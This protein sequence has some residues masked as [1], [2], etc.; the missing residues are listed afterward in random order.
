M[1]APSR[2]ASNGGPPAEPPAH[3]YIPNSAP[4]VRRQMLDAIGI[5]SVDE[6]YASV[7][8]ELRL[9]RPLDLPAPLTDEVALRRHVQGL[10]N[11]NT[12]T[13]EVVSFLGGGC[14]DLHVP[15]VVDE[16]TGRAEFVTAYGGG[17]YADHGKYQILFEFQSLIGELVGMDVVSAPTYDGITATTSALLMACRLTNRGR[18]LVPATVNPQL[19]EHLRTF[20]RPWATVE[21]IPA[22]PAS[23]L[24]DLEAL[25]GLLG[26]DVGAVLVEMPSYLGFVEEGVHEVA[27][28]VHDA[29]GLLVAAVDPV[30][31]G[32]LA[33]P[34]AY[35]ADIVAGDSQPLGIHQ[36][37][38][39]GQCG[40]IAHRDEEAYVRE[41]PS[42]LI[43]AVPSRDGEA[44]GF[45]W[46]LLSSTSYDLRGDS[47]D[48]T[49]TSQWLW[50][51]G[52]AVHLALLGPHGLAEL[53]EGLVGRA[54]YL[55]RRLAE[56]PGVRA[57]LLGRVHGREL[58]VGFDGTGR[59]VAEVNRALR[60]KGI[61]GGHDLS[62]D[63]PWLG[64]AALYAVSDRTGQAEIDGLAAA[65]REIVT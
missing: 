7:P 37:F 54:A 51:M 5:Q 35:G 50:G 31:L 62:V 18:I 58:V 16:I 46:T 1:S 33:A 43:S 21:V 13:S 44:V 25:R 26:P 32:V 38:G 48:F 6:L 59:S 64:Q 52:A 47:R 57:P 9:Q 12:A 60:A 63:F 61:F 28:A 49:G 22:E 39:G 24:L 34:A 14:W 3:P 4:G 41:N 42:I 10:L 56:I 19:R 20:A 36:L 2:P 8:A 65:L 23:G 11:R 15:A 27:K 45:A 55:R 53:G 29:G 17:P 40:F 30:L